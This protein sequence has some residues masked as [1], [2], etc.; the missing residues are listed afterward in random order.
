MVVVQRCYV[1]RLLAEAVVVCRY[2]GPVTYDK[3]YADVKEAFMK[4]FFGPPKSGVYSPSVQY[5][6]YEMAKLALAR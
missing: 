3:A 2:S 4:G 6:L 1:K 5:T